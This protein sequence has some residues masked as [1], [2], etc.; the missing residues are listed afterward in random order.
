METIFEAK[1]I[2]I[3]WYDKNRVSK[4]DEAIL[5]IAIEVENDATYSM[6]LQT[7]TR[8]ENG[9]DGQVAF[10]LL[11]ESTVEPYF[12]D[13]SNNRVP[14]LKI[15]DPKTNKIWWIEDGKWSKQH[16]Y[17]SSLLWNH[18]GETKVIFDNVTCNI[19]IR[20]NSFTREQLDLYLKDFRNDFWYLILQNASLTQGDAKNKKVKL[21]DENSIKFIEKFIEY[22]SKILQNPKKELREVQNLKDIK[23]VKPVARTFMEIATRGFKKKMTS[24]DTIESYNVAE[25]RYIHYAIQQVYTIVSNILNAS[26]HIKEIYE[27]KFEFDKER[28]KSFTDFKTIDKEVFENE[29]KELQT[30]YDNEIPNL[31]KCIYQQNRDIDISLLKK[32]TI[33]IQ[34]GKRTNNENK[35]EFFGNIKKNFIDDWSSFKDEKYKNTKYKD[36]F[37][38][39]A[40]NKDIFEHKIQSNYEYKITGYV[41]KNDYPRNS[42]GYKL[43]REFIFISNIKIIK[44]KVKEQ[45]DLKVLEKKDLEAT[46]WQRKLNYQEQQEQ[47]YEKKA[48]QKQLDRLNTEQN[49]NLD[50]IKGLEPSLNKLKKLLQQCQELKIKQDSY[51]PNSMTFIQNPN[52]QGTHKYFKK[53]KDIVGV[54][55]SLFVHMQLVEKIGLLDIPTIYERWC[56]LQIIKVLIEKY[57]FTPETNWKNKLANQTVGNLNN[58]KNIKISFSNKEIARDIDLWYEKELSNRKRPDFVLD[59]KS[60]FGTNKIHRL[61]MDAKFHEEVDVEGQI[62]LLYHHKNYSED[63]KN[64]VFILHPDANKSIKMKKTPKEWG[65]DAYYGEVEMFNFDWDEDKKPNHKYGAILLSPIARSGNFLDSLQRLIGMSMQYNMEDNESCNDPEPKEKVFCLICGSNSHR[66]NRKQT[67]SG[68]GYRYETVCE[69]CRHQYMYNYC[70]SCNYRLIKNGRYWSYHSSR[71]LEEFDILCPQCNVFLLRKDKS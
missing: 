48:L 2:S 57:H 25:N 30:K 40:F 6:E 42:V 71:A 37:Y 44:S 13:A 55:E 31:H 66:W 12:L 54:D 38:M 17:R 27:K 58:L 63:N 46:S 52:Y 29:I 41:V 53:V 16:K 28:L 59:I 3:K 36:S 67:K 20:A 22:S 4:I 32:E 50:L 14:L 34:L 70:W 45:L 9:L 56:F 43:Q 51:F 68:K 47:E 10:H 35:F 23:K 39:I 24:R 60:T 21:L 49:D 26:G 61:V 15:I 5:P 69:E 62:D 64:T 8:I 33:F 1:Y 11:N 18:I 65:N 7:Y 19:N